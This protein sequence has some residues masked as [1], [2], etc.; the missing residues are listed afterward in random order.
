ILE[1]HKFAFKS[2]H[3][4]YL[5]AN[6]K[7]GTMDLRNWRIEWESFE[8]IKKEN[9]FLTTTLDG[10]FLGAED[11][12]ITTMPMSKWPKGNVYESTQS[13]IYMPLILIAMYD[14]GLRNER[15]LPSEKI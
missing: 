2:T 13:F 5:S 8:L 10:S 1:N 15:H 14:V 12:N 11:Y 9:Q 3:G 6:L 7:Y 4:T